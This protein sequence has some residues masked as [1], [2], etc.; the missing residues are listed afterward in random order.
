MKSI[1]CRSSSN[2][3]GRNWHRKRDF[4]TFRREPARPWN[5]NKKHSG[6]APSLR[7]KESEL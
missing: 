6:L 7:K 5:S 3:L 1:N 4:S 2:K